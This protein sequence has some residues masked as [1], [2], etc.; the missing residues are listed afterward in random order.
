[1][2]IIESK[3][4]VSSEVTGFKLDKQFLSKHRSS[5]LPSS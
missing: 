3:D 4:V 5:Q 1:M 2:E